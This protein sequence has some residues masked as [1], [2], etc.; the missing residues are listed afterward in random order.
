VPRAQTVRLVHPAIGELHLVVTTEGLVLG[1]G[2]EADVDLG[3]DPLVSRRHARLMLRA[4]R[5]WIEDVGSHN[6]IWIGDVRVSDPVALSP[7][8]SLLLGETALEVAISF[9][10]GL[11]VGPTQDLPRREAREAEER[12][13]DVSPQPDPTLEAPL[14]KIDR[15]RPDPHFFGRG[16]SKSA[17][18]LSLSSRISMSTGSENAF[19]SSPR[20]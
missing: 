1:R 11:P 10:D 14:E 6:G 12:T 17:V 13:L 4:E 2:E 8:M 5:I 16:K 20:I 19:A 7:G 15:V 9:N 18:A 3:W